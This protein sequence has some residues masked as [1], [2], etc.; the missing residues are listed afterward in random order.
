MG[1]MGRRSHS[2]SHNPRDQK[3]SKSQDKGA[4]LKPGRSM[5]AQ[6]RRPRHTLMLAAFS[7][8]YGGGHLVAWNFEFPTMIEGCI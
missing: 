2:F 4:L 8:L 3:V 6:E 5:R 1:F 7:I